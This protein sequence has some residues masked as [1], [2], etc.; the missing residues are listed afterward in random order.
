M[1]RLST[2]NRAS[3]I[4]GERD[5]SRSCSSPWSRLLSSSS[6]AVGGAAGLGN[7]DAFV[8]D[9]E[10]EERDAVEDSVFVR[11]RD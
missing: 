11:T 9:F 6:R 4:S 7:T 8:V 10:R 3:L 2:Y 1:V 5:I